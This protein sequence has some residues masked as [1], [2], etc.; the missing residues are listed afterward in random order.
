MVTAMRSLLHGVFDPQ[1][2]MIRLILAEKGLT[3]RL[4]PISPQ[5]AQEELAGYNPAMTVPV[6]ID[7]A[8]SGQELSISPASA[9]AEYLEEVYGAPLLF[10]STSAGRAETR[11]L[12]AWFCDKMEEEVIARTVRI[13][14]DHVQLGRSHT[15]ENAEAAAEALAWH[16]DYLSWLLEKRAWLAGEQFTVAD[17]TGGAYFSTLDY[18]GIVPWRDF[19]H[20]K[21]WYQHLKSR[22][23]FQPLLKERVDGLPPPAHYANL[24]F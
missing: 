5:D 21:E 15:D 22:P 18:L 9:I 8:P 2:R 3:V 23:S 12:I 1:S 6:L 13:K 7:E 16:L 20:V 24:D 11:R 17:L 4:G 14:I 10:P 19:P